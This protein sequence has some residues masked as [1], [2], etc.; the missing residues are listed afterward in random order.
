MN[1]EIASQIQRQF[2]WFL[3]EIS[4]E[5][6]HFSDNSIFIVLFYHWLSIL[7]FYFCNCI[8]VFITNTRYFRLIAL[9]YYITFY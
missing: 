8:Y 3:A 2:N 5:V 1:A 4:L 9:I 6:T 7:Q